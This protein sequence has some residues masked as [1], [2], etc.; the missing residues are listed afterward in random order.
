V[1]V[2]AETIRPGSAAEGAAA[3]AVVILGCVLLMLRLQ[4]LGRAGAAPL[5]AATYVA[6]LGGAILVRVPAA[7]LD[8]RPST[9]PVVAAALVGIGAVVVAALAAGPSIPV[10]VPAW[11]PAMNALAAIGEEALFRRTAFGWLA[12]FGPVA[13][14]VA[15]AVLF[16]LVHVPVY[17]ASALPVDLG[18]GLLF[19]WQRAVSGTW[20]VP[21]TTHVVANLVTVLR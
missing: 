3:A 13:A 15:T 5:L 2:R 4:V 14:V 18:A 20:T 16:A 7:R 6:I 11:A 21:A 1:S 12:Q 17:G 9:A 19:G 10:S 8:G